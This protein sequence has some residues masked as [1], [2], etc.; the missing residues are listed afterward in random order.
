MTTPPRRKR[1]PTSAANHRENSPKSPEKSIPITK[2]LSKTPEAHRVFTENDEIQLLK[3]ISGSPNNSEFTSNGN[4]TEKQIAKKL[5]RLKEKYHKL[6]RSKSL[7]KTPHDKKIYEIARQI[8]GRN[9]AKGKEPGVELHRSCE[10]EKGAEV[11]VEV[12]EEVN[13]EEFPFL[14]SEMMSI[15]GRSEYCKEGLR[16]LGKEK[17]KRMN[18]KWMELRL[19]E[20]EIMVNKAKLYHEQLK[21]VVEGSKGTDNEAN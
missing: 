13:L 7:I 3:T 10:E 6:A 15:F 19:K 2:T 18:E 1:N 9:A 5:K 4:F 20:A 16:R 21:L 12:E 8:W 14:V 17:L 11:E